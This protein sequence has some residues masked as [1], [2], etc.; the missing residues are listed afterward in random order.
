MTKIKICGL[1]SRSDAEL[2]NE[3]DVDYAG[4][5]MFFQKSHRNTDP[6]TAGRIVRALREG[7]I[8]VAV[9]VRPTY[10]EIS[11]AARLGFRYIQIHGDVSR[12]LIE[13]SPLLVIKAFNVDDLPGL[14]AYNTYDNIMGYVFD[15][16]EP[17]SGKT[18]DW[19]MLRG[20]DTGDRM[21]MLAGGLNAG[22]VAEAVK[23]AAPD[24]VDV[25]SGTENENRTGKS[26]QKIAAFVSAV[27]G[28]E[29]RKKH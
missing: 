15:A 3:F 24:A 20:L 12:E 8:P 28:A 13:S 19:D 10:D 27:R 11:E 2:V 17:G 1:M 21:V 7:I 5:V 6:D 23:H 9:T 29:A 14:R 26:R 22:N 16:A 18:F 4:V 25:S